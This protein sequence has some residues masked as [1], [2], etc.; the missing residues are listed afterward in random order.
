MLNMLNHIG[1]FVWKM[2]FFLRKCWICWICWMILES[3]GSFAY[4]FKNIQ[5]IQ[6]IQHLQKSTFFKQDLQ[7]IQH[8]QHFCRKKHIFQTRSP[9]WF[10]IF[11]ISAERSIFLTSMKF[12][13]WMY[14]KCIFLQFRALFY[15]KCFYFCRNKLFRPN[16][17]HKNTQKSVC[18]SLQKYY[19]TGEK[20]PKLS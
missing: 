15:W 5:H 7:H 16:G 14:Q 18:F 3:I 2:C 1:D 11:N 4:R 12:R 20:L 17:P 10:N 19:K 6:H 9:T 8:I 13:I